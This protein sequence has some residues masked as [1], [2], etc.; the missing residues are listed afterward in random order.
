MCNHNN[1]R[2]V[3]I[4]G[5][6]ATDRTILAHTARVCLGISCETVALERQSLRDS[7]DEYWKTKKHDDDGSAEHAVVKTVVGVL[8][9]HLPTLNLAYHDH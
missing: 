6:G 2:F 1:K 7:V 4:V 5:D 3:G 8:A 9:V